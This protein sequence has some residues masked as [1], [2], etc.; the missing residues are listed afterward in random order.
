MGIGSILGSAALRELLR[1]SPQIITAADQAY[2]TVTA[3]R[4]QGSRPDSALGDRLATLEAADV[5]QAELMAT[6]AAQLQSQAQTLE[7]LAARQKILTLL[8]GGALAVAVLSCL[9]VLSLSR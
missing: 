7:A 2:K 1:L 9:L 6:M 8:A 5:A 4:T 3:N